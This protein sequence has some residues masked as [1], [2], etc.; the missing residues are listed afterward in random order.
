[1]AGWPRSQKVCPRNLGVAHLRLPMKIRNPSRITQEMVGHRHTAALAMYTTSLCCPSESLAVSVD[2]STCWSSLD[3]RNIHTSMV[4]S[5][6]VFFSVNIACSHQYA[7]LGTC[8]LGICALQG[9]LRET[10]TRSTGSPFGC[11]QQQHTHCK[12]DS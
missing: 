10:Y 2:L 12:Y 6:S 9:C 4:D 3:D 7:G 11:H 8:F 1:M 5:I